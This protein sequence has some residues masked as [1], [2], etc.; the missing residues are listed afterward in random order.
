MPSRQANM[1]ATDAGTT[2]VDEQTNQGPPSDRDNPL[3]GPTEDGDEVT[4]NN[5]DQGLQSSTSQAP[6]EDKASPPSNEDAED[7]DRMV[8][9]AGTTS[10]TPTHTATNN[11]NNHNNHNNHNSKHTRPKM[12]QDKRRPSDSGSNNRNTINKNSRGRE[13]SGGH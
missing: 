2:T 8:E 4:R 10:T 7:A 1:A 3:S 11:N 12:T 6:T 9:D 5:E 13:K